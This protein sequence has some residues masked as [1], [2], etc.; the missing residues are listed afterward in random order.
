MKQL[1]SAVLQQPLAHVTTISL[2]LAVSFYLSFSLSHT[3]I[4]MGL[5]S[6]R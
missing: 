5:L 6:K 1:G 4:H 3:Y 2:P